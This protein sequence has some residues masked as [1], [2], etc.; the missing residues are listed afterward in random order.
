MA[1]EIREDS[2]SKLNEAALDLFGSSSPTE[3]AAR[4]VDLVTEVLGLAGATVYSFDEGAGALK[5]LAHSA[6]TDCDQSQSPTAI[7]PGEGFVWRLFAEGTDEVIEDVRTDDV[8]EHDTPFRSEMGVPLGEHGVLVVGG[9]GP[10]AFD[11]RSRDII[12]I[13]ATTAEAAIGHVKRRRD[14]ETRE[15]QLAER[16]EQLERLEAINSR[17]RDVARATVHS[18]TRGEIEQTVC[19]ELIEPDSFGFA[20]IGAVDPVTDTL[21]PRATAGDDR[22]YLDAVDLSLADQSVTEPAVRTVRTHD[23][24]VV[25]NAA[26]G[27]TRAEWREETVQRGYRSLMSI[28]LVYQGTLRGVLTVFS[29][30]ESIVSERLQAV[31]SELGELIAHAIVAAERKQALLANQSTELEFDIQDPACFFL[32]FAQETNCTLELEQII[33]RSDDTSLVVVK[34]P[35]GSPKNLLAEAEQSS[36][37]KTADQVESDGEAVIQLQ[38]V[39]PFI[40]SILADHG[41]D[42]RNISANDTECRVTVGIPPTANIH[43]VVDVVSTTYTDTEVLAKREQTQ[44]PRSKVDFADRVLRELTPR[45]R[46]VSEMAYLSGYFESPREASGETLA[47]ELEFSASAFH[48]HIRAAE[49]KLFGAVFETDRS[50]FGKRG[51]DD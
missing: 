9:T 1:E 47:G 23:P 18:A 19:E 44:Y 32:R 5:P 26:T 4:T 42:L 28:P 25:T 14:L 36:T 24:V 37:V 3:V 40:G 6:D 22:G 20:W 13:L 33:P 7:E 31:L 34:V 48:H 27:I 10:D 29:A 17:I 39:E 11:S 12:R 15:R 38:I 43:Q 21:T 45:Q 46:E 49:R 8:S 30:E 51:S 16:T 2:L 41:I 50:E 35:V